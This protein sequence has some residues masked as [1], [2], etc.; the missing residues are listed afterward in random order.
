MHQFVL[1][2]GEDDPFAANV[3]ARFAVRIS[4][5]IAKVEAQPRLGVLGPIPAYGREV[6][7]TPVVIVVSGSIDFIAVAIDR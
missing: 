2:R 4:D 1:V 6:P 7:L 5:E 3:N